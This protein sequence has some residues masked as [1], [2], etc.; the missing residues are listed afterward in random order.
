MTVLSE[1]P[2]RQNPYELM[3]LKGTQIYPSPLWCPITLEGH[4]RKQ[5]WSPFSSL[6]FCPSLSSFLCTSFSQ[7]D[8]VSGNCQMH[9]HPLAFAL[10]TCSTWRKLPS[11]LAQNVF[12]SPVS[13]LMYANPNIYI[14]NNYLLTC[15]RP[16]PPLWDIS[17]TRAG[18]VHHCC[19]LARI[20]TFNILY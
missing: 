5:I 10:A 4:R 7:M 19:Y 2:D 18:S 3:F 15:L 12:P 13:A 9:P 20:G 1:P 14:V 6:I 17:S 8:L 16:I 11:L